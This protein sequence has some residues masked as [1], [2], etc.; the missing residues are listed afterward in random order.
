MEAAAAADAAPEDLQEVQ[1]GP[2][3]DNEPDDDL[4]GVEADEGEEG[5]AGNEDDFLGDGPCGKLFAKKMKE[6]KITLREAMARYRVATR[7]LR[8]ML[9]SSFVSCATSRQGRARR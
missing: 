1:P 4:A 7:R 8:L 9:R 6:H 3:E 5:F 2:G